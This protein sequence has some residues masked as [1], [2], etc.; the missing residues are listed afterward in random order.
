MTGRPPLAETSGVMD[1]LPS[2]SREHDRAHRRYVETLRGYRNRPGGFWVA[3]S[4]PRAADEALTGT[5]AT[6]DIT[7]AV[8]LSD[9][10]SRLVDRFNLATWPQLVKLVAD[11]GPDALIDRVRAIEHSDPDGRRWPRGKVTDDAT[12]AFLAPISDDM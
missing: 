12:V 2:G 11:E 4:D 3:S 5:V 6:R 8:L 1:D 7:A 10:A 9:G